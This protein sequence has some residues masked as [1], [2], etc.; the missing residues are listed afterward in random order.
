MK[1]KENVFR[2]FYNRDLPRSFGMVITLFSG[3]VLTVT[4][5]GTL[6][7][8]NIYTIIASVLFALISAACLIV[9]LAAIIAAYETVE[10]TQDGLVVRFLG[11]P[12]YRVPGSA[13]RSVVPNAREY[14]YQLD[15]R[16]AFMLQ[17]YWNGSR[18]KNRALW[19]QWS[20]AT[21]AALRKSFPHADFLL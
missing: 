3:F 18:P 13:L 21:E 11:L 5:V 16:Q 9:G 12:I 19:I 14:R 7:D 8:T 20:K 10:I 1:N 17:L 6:Q 2:R 15:D 4:V